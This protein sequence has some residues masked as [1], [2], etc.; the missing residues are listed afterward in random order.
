MKKSEIH[1][2]R[3]YTEGRGGLRQVLAEGPQYKMYPGVVDDDCL[4][5]KAV[6]SA[7]GPI[8]AG[9][10]GNITRVSFAAWAQSEVQAS[11]V[12]Q[13]L[14]EH[15]AKYVAKKLTAVQRTFL[16]SFDRDL[17]LTSQIE[18]PREEYRAAKAC[19][20]K[21]LVSEMPETLKKTDS[22][23]ELVFTALGL[24]VLRVVHCS[25]VTN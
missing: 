16:E 6:R 7:G 22:S 8:A 13:W 18:C 1:V 4:R 19:S 15:E 3:F 21:G 5:Y 20:E 23:F 24:A 12:E 2:G 10:E 17:N 25:S 14:I 11:V 9:T